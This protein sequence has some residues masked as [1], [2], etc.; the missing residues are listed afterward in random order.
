MK[1]TLVKFFWAAAS[2]GAALWLLWFMIR[3]NPP[4]K[5]GG[6]E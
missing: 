1:E 5:G 4:K 6:R 3:Y 2:L